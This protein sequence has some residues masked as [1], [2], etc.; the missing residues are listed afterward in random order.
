MKKKDKSKINKFKIYM[1]M[2]GVFT[3]VLNGLGVWFLLSITRFATLN[4]NLFLFINLLVV[5]GLLLVNVGVLVITRQKKPLVKNIFIAFLCILVVVGG[6]GNYAVFTIN[7][8]INLIAGGGEGQV[9]ESR[10]VAF[11]TY[12]NN[13]IISVNDISGNRFGIIDNEY[14]LEGNYLAILEINRLNLTVEFVHFQN[15]TDMVLA[16]L[17]RTI[18]IAALPANFTD[19]FENNDNILEHLENTNVIHSFSADVVLDNIVASDIDVTREPF[20]VLILGDA[21]MRTNTIMVAVVNPINLTVSLTSIPRDSFVPIACYRGQARDKLAHARMVSRQCVIDTVE[22]LLDIEIDFY[23]ETGFRGMVDIVDALGGLWVYSPIEFV[24]QNSSAER[25]HFTVWVPRGLNHLNGE[26]VLAFT[27]ERHRFAAGDFARQENQQQVI[28]TL[29]QEIA[30]LRSIDRALAVFNA[31]GNNIST[32][33]T[34]EQMVE[35]LNHL[36]SSV[37]NSYRNDGSII[38]VYGNR[39]TGYAS[40]VF[41]EPSGLILWIYRLYDGAIA[42]ARRFINYNLRIGTEPTIPNTFRFVWNWGFIAT[43]P[44][45]QNWYNELQIHLPLPEVVPNMVA[46]AWTLPQAQTWAN[47]HGITLVVN[48][49][50]PGH[51]SYSEHFAQDQIIAQSVPA[52]RLVG[53]TTSITIDVIKHIEVD[54]EIVDFRGELI[55]VAQAWAEANGLVFRTIIQPTANSALHGIIHSTDPVP[56]ATIRRGAVFTVRVYGPQEM[57]SVRFEGNGGTVEGQSFVDRTVVSGA[58]LGNANIPNATRSEYTFVSWNTAADGSGITFTA[59]TIVN[60]NMTVFAIWT[61]T[62]P[63]MC[64]WDPSIP[65][66]DPNCPATCPTDPTIPETD[67]NC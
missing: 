64:Q 24:G 7:R 23:V 17:A 31:A 27:R 14:F 41:N 18:D 13:R 1:I 35:L 32:N 8:N 28:Q 67:P 57:V 38:R 60:A 3:V 12:D 55:S 5:F 49:I 16:L 50:R 51:S 45:I 9:Q 34:F 36:M 43:D 33:M 56:G 30:N 15:Y 10:D 26:Q 59:A 42:D 63:P 21:G 29:I 6:Y 62:P 53:N 48:E 37:N 54:I 46:G 39:I 20:T 11:V 4:R 58:N 2:F 19:L 66:T 47:T 65:A 22:N 52:G 61:L 40:H 25:G 44:W